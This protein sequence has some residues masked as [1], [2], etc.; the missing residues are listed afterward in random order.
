MIVKEAPPKKGQ[1]G[2]KPSWTDNGVEVSVHIRDQD[3]ERLVNDP[4]LFS[5]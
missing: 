4:C 1:G 5:F 3:M 2:S